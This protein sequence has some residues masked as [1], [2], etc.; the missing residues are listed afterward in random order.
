[1]GENG[2]NGGAGSLVRYERQGKVGVIT[3]DRRPL[4]TY[5]DLV[6]AEF[7]VAWRRA[8]DD[9]EAK[10]VVMLATGKHFCAGHELNDFQGV[11]D[12]MELMRPVDEMRL[13]RSVMKPTI[14]AVQGGCVGGGQ[15]KVWPCD[16]VFCTEDAFFRDPT[17]GMGIGGIQSH[18]HTWFYGPRLAKEM[19]YSGM[20]LPATRLY[21]M[22]QV[23]RLYPDLETLHTETLAF[24]AQIAEQDPAA[25]RQAKRAADITMDIMGAHYVLSR[26]DEL[27]DA[28]P[29]M[30][31]PTSD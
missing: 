1:M 23:N 12:G 4:N 18:L 22:G 26:F 7:Q 5:D 15:R 16:L 19:I 31:H 9:D 11:P 24:A 30:T 8:K 6:E 20:R 25:L 27:T 14:A 17:V 29:T 13:I 21:A 3:L 28:I 10:V 2:T